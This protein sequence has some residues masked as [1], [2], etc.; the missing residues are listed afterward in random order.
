MGVLSYIKLALDRTMVQSS[1]LV[2]LENDMGAIE[3]MW[4]CICMSVHLSVRA[5]TESCIFMKLQCILII[6]YILCILC[7]VMLFGVNL[8]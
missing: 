6:L 8:C 3:W 7:Y 5:W 2:C 1:N 4:F